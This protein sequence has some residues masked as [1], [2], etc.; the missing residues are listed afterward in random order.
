M[1][2]YGIKL[3]PD[4]NGTLLA[5]CPDLPGMVTFG[6]GRL[7][8]LGRAV[9]AIEEWIAAAINDGRDVPRPKR[10]PGL[11]IVALPAMTALKVELYRAVREAGI[12]RAELTRRLHW[13]RES[14]DRLF[15]LDHAS[16][17]PQIEA[18]ARVLKK[19]VD[20]RIS[21]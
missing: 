7:D 1:L 15:R 21:A 8:A 17:L 12:S 9:G 4:D 18:A 6:E 5:T 14:V 20:I 19:N 3:E 10:H 13:K 2:Q 16:R 11:D